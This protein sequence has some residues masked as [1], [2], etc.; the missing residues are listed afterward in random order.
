MLL[1]HRDGNL[2]GISPSAGSGVRTWRQSISPQFRLAA[3]RS[4]DDPY[5][6]LTCPHAASRF[7]VL[8]D[9]PVRFFSG[10]TSKAL[11]GAIARRPISVAMTV[12]DRP[13]TA[14]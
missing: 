9:P 6:L 2:N 13:L 1:I 11:T 4:S 8:T 7:P 12:S 3:Q 5:S 10:R 14:L